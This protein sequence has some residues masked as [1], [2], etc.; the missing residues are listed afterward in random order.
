MMDSFRLVNT[1]DRSYWIDLLLKISSPILSNMSTNNLKRKMF[2]KYSP[3]WNGR[4]KNI[5]YLEAFGRTMAGITPWLNCCDDDSKEALLR[6][7]ILNWALQAY[8]H[9]VDSKSPDYITEICEPQNL[10]DTAYI[11]LSFIRAPEVTWD[12]LDDNTKLRYIKLFNEI[13]CVKPFFNNWLLFRAIIEAFLMSIGERY[14]KEILLYIIK[15]VNQWYIGDGWY[16]DGPEFTFDYYNSFTIHPMLVE[17]IELCKKNQIETSISFDLALR[18]M[19]RYNEHLEHLISPEGTFPIIGRSITYRMGVFQP[20]ALSAWKYGL[21]TSLN[22]GQVRNALT[23]TMKNI[24]RDS[25]DNFTA[26]G[27]LAIGFTSEQNECANYYIN[28]GSLYMTSLVFLPLGLPN[29][30]SFWLSTAER[31]TSLKAWNGL[32]FDK[33]YYQSIKK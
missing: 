2:V 10:V 5:A 11:A 17:I 4:N 29:N 13:R 26:E 15:T 8:T 3:T 25:N 23:C 18:R 16:C 6:K 20:L 27:F 22:E 12:C 30:S 14:N 9:S 28:T 31:W 1:K 24:F 19:Q 21:P 32:S 33:D 7:K